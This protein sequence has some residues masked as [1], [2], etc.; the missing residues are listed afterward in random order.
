[1]PATRRGGPQTALLDT[2]EG[3]AD[4]GEQDTV[5]APPLGSV[6]ALDAENGSDVADPQR[7][8]PVPPVT[9]GALTDK[10]KAL[11]AAREEEEEGT[12]PR[13]GLRALGW[14]RRAESINGRLAMLAFAIILA[15]EYVSDSTLP[16]MLGG[17][18]TA[19]SSSLE[20]ISC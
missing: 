20:H 5:R 18:L 6:E 12:A 9:L 2:S 14:T 11:A 10:Y 1:M 16:S 8:P 7:S 17:M 13:R 19:V 15:R 4:E 3:T